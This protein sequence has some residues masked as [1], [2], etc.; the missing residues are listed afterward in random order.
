[1][2]FLSFSDIF[3]SKKIIPNFAKMLEN[4]FLP[5][6]EATVNPQKHK[7]IHILLKYVSPELIAFILIICT[8]KLNKISFA[9]WK[10]TKVD[11]QN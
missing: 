10:R 11:Y 2:C 8:N 1:M 4:I 6:F 5:L 9:Y 3:R 7:E